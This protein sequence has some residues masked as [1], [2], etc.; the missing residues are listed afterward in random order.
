MELESSHFAPCGITQWGLIN[1][2]FHPAIL[3][4]NADDLHEDYPNL[5]PT[6]ISPLEH[7]ETLALAAHCTQVVQLKQYRRAFT[8]QYVE[9]HQKLDQVDPDDIEQ[10]SRVGD[11]ETH[12]WK[13]LSSTTP[14][15]G[16]VNALHYY[17][18]PH[19]FIF[20]SY[21]YDPWTREITESIDDNRLRR[22]LAYGHRSDSIRQVELTPYIQEPAGLQ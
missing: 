2:D 6:I 11:Y 19:L 12:T 14:F 4:I 20:R 9:S 1:D 7:Q 10:R 15:P 8:R 13:E 17:R 3:P 18:Q 5:K 21:V 16:S 22:D